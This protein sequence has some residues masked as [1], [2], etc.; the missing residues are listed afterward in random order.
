MKICSKCRT[1]RPLDEYLK[2]P[3]TRDKLQCWCNPCRKAHRKVEPSL[4][5]GKRW[6]K[7]YRDRESV[8]RKSR[9]QNWL[10]LGIKLTCDEYDEMLAAQHGL[11]AICGQA[12]SARRL[13]VDHDHRTGRIRGLLCRNCN[14][15]LGLMADDP[16]RILS[17][18]AY[19]E[20]SIVGGGLSSKM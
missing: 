8:I 17:A 16:G 1:P 13:H 11:C 3:Y 9:E 20:R 18:A 19:L 12:S 14:I 15:C 7:K 2:H 5:N 6:R 10:S 4:S